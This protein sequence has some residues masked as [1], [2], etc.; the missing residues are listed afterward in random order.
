MIDNLLSKCY[1]NQVAG[2]Q[3]MLKSWCRSLKTE[4]C[5]V[6]NS[7]ELDISQSAGFHSMETKPKFKLLRQRQQKWASK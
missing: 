5:K 2:R 3:R 6:T 7:L 1:Y 4:Q